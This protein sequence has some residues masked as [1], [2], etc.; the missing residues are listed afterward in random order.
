MTQPCP[1]QYIL[2]LKGKSAFSIFQLKKKVRPSDDDTATVGEKPSVESL[3]GGAKKVSGMS[4]TKKTEV[5]REVPTMTG[6]FT[7]SSGSADSKEEIPTLTDWKQNPDG[8]ITGTVK[9]SKSFK[10]G[11]SISTSPVLKGAKAGSIVRTGAGSLY[12]L[13]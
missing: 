12:R 11:T 7:G 2:N 4:S 8:C 9:K 5:K 3:F 6:R 13:L 10:D 1:F